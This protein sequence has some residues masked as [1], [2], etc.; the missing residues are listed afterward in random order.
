MIYELAEDDF[1]LVAGGTG[2]PE[3]PEGQEV[4]VTARVMDSYSPFTNGNFYL[5]MSQFGGSF[6]DQ[7]FSGSAKISISVPA[8]TDAEGDI[9]VEATKEQ[10]DAAKDAFA[11]AGDELS[12]ITVLAA[13]FGGT[14]E[15][16]A[17]AAVSGAG[18][19]LDLNM[20]EAKAKLADYYYHLDAADGSYDGRSGD[21]IRY[22]SISDLTPSGGNGP[23]RP[24]QVNH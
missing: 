7:L 12:T 3:I 4:V 6:V 13:I 24:D 20:D 8:P 16:Y 17:G 11:M 23:D 10:V 19:V 22:F 5:T 9:V 2:E 1:A 18:V 21:P 15:K 14:L